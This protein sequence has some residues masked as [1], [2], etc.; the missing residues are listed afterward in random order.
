M[1]KKIDFIVTGRYLHVNGIE[2]GTEYAHHR[3]SYLV[4]TASGLYRCTLPVH[5]EQ[6]SSTARALAESISTTDNRDDMSDVRI[7]GNKPLID[8]YP[9]EKR[10]ALMQKFDH[11]LMERPQVIVWRWDTLHVGESPE[12]YFERHAKAIE[13]LGGRIVSEPTFD[14]N[15]YQREYM[16]KKR[17]EDRSYGQVKKDG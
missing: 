5:L 16:R 15:T 14:K 8:H 12:Q 9:K 3:G 2:M 11:D 6:L 4:V 1:I 13:A 7:E 17:L 10:K